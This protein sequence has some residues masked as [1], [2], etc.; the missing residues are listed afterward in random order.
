MSIKKTER[1]KEMNKKEKR[2][3]EEKKG[4]FLKK[5]EQVKQ[6]VF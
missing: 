5:S 6:E 3:I 4:K 1:M 2:L